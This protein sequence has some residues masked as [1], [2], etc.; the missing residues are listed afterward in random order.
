MRRRLRVLLP[1]AD[2]LH[3]LDVDHRVPRRVGV[4]VD[5][6]GAV[7]HDLAIPTAHDSY[8]ALLADPGVDAVYIPLPNHLHAEWTIKAA[9]EAKLAVAQAKLDALASIRRLID[10]PMPQAPQGLSDDALAAVHIERP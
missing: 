7:A 4:P 2:V 1:H 8:E 9:V 5:V 3:V 6:R 10:M